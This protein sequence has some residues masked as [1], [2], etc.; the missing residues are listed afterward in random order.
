ASIAAL[1]ED[2]LG[3]VFADVRE[4]EQIHVVTHSLGGILVRRY[5]H[6]HGVPA[7]LGR[8]VMLAPPN[9]GSEIVD[10]LAG[11][12]P[13]R[14][15]NGPAGLELGTGPEAMAV[16]LGPAPDGVEIGVTAGNRSWNPLFSALIS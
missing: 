8:V 2:A 13:Y 5:L 7:S 6:D 4:G 10:T 16:A 14:W 3:P 15:I 12:R 9:G 11:W 1:A